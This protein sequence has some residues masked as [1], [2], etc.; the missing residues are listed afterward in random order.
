MFLQKGVCTKIL[1]SSKEEN[2]YIEKLQTFAN[3]EVL[4]HFNK[5]NFI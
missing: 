2:M 4:K 5:L 3:I 1:F